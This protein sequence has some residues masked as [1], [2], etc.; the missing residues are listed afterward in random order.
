MV[1]VVSITQ[2]VVPVHKDRRSAVKQALWPKSSPLLICGQYCDL[3]SGINLQNAHSS[4]TTTTA[5]IPLP[6]GKKSV[7]DGEQCWSGEIVLCVF[8]STHTVL[9]VMSS[10]SLVF[11]VMLVIH[12][13]GGLMTLKGHPDLLKRNE[14]LWGGATEAL[15]VYATTAAA[16]HSM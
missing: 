16:A 7:R 4:S 15:G 9:L 2:K 14:R 1:E 10:L 8:D 3:F 12:W 5:A 6:L 11:S 13:L